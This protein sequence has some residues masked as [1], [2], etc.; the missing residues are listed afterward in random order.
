DKAVNEIVEVL[1]PD[2]VICVAKEITKLHENFWVGP[3]AEVRN[4]LAKASHKGEF[5]L[6]IAP[7]DF[8]L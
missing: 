4:A 5:V 8:E 2:R 3:A 7:A 1:G 6:L